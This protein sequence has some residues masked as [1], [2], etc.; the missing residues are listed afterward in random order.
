MNAFYTPAGPLRH[1]DSEPDKSLLKRI[2]TPTLILGAW[3]P[4]VAVSLFHYFTGH[5][6]LHIHDILR[7]LYYLPI[8]VGALQLGLLGGLL[9]AL[10]VT[11]A[12]IPH[13][14]ILPHHF[15]PADGIEKILEIGIYFVMGAIA[16]YLSDREQRQRR[17]TEYA[18]REQ[19]ALQQQLVRAGRLS[20]LGQTV[21][22]IAH[23]IKN[24]LHSL[25]GTSE[26]VDNVV[27]VDCDERRLW[28]IHVSEIKRLQNI[29]DRFLSFARPSPSE[30][31]LMDLRDVAERIRDLYGA[32]ARQSDLSLAI[33][34][35]DGPVHV[36]ADRD[37]LAQLAINI[38]IN[39]EKAIGAR[40]GGIRL[41]VGTEVKNGLRMAFLQIENDG[42]PVDIANVESL[43]DPFYS[44]TD[45]TGLG[46]SISSRIAQQHDGFI[47][48]ANKGIGVAF[49]L[50]LPAAD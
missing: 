35:P 33:A 36:R 11:L 43:F 24:P 12:Y 29:A 45:S 31:T 28:E 46:L 15:D 3:I 38:F 34:L 44:G 14:F 10:L 6:Q 47:D 5:D 22:G 1:T 18:L 48:V 13:A 27:P 19:A 25:L 30:M 21:A 49:T 37:L 16:G 26:I 50:Y 4:L 20:A 39:A 17:R 41:S 23:E 42:P 40:K 9:F 7:R 8:V 32:Q 2:F